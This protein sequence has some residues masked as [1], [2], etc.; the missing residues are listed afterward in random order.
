MTESDGP[1]PDLL[2]HLR[3]RARQLVAERERQA[4]D[5]RAT[6]AVLDQMAA[7]P[8]EERRR[9]IAAA[10]ARM[11]RL[12]WRGI[13]GAVITGTGLGAAWRLAA[14]HSATAATAL[15][16]A[17]VLGVTGAAIW[18]PPPIIDGPGRGDSGVRRPA[19]PAPSATPTVGETATPKPSLPSP[20]P[21]EPPT[22]EPSPTPSPGETSP[23]PEPGTPGIDPEPDPPETPPETPDP[24][25]TPNP[26]AQDPPPSRGEC[27]IRLDVPPILDVCASYKPRPPRPR[28][29]AGATPHPHPPGPGRPSPPRTPAPA[30]A[31]ATP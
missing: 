28:S 7:G 23:E 13:V 25:G 3:E 1:R 31:P 4:A 6:L 15:G 8:E 16:G 30:Y 12:G 9:R 29:G 20:S 2:E 10:R 19:V 26:P 17:A 21:S 24:P 11:R 5:A 18:L 22:A 14:G 27:T